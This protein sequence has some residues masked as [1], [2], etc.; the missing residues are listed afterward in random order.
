SDDGWS[1]RIEVTPS[2]PFEGTSV[3]GHAVVD[4]PTLESLIRQIE[5]ETGVQQGSYSLT[6]IPH[7]KVEGTANGSPISSTHE[8]PYVLTYNKQSLIPDSTLSSSEPEKITKTVDQ[9]NVIN[10]GAFS[11]SVSD[12]RIA[13][14]TLAIMA[15]V[16]GAVLASVV[17]L[18]LG[19][20]RLVQVFCRYQLKLVNAT[21]VNEPGI[22]RVRLQSLNDLAKIARRESGII[23]CLTT[24]KEDLLFVPAGAVTFEYLLIDEHVD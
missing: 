16:S 22:Q 20:N 6:V 2:A 23:F 21:A 17:F 5:A 3:T 13:G 24:P 1:K 11:A 9:E 12:A 19:R 4:F 18:G 7:V 10:F 8:F 14:I 15:L